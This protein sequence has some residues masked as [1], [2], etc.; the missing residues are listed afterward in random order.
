MFMF[1]GN[2]IE[3]IKINNTEIIW[4]RKLVISTSGMMNIIYHLLSQICFIKD[5]S[6]N[7]INE[8][9]IGGE[10]QN[11][12]L[13][14]GKHLELKNTKDNPATLKKSCVVTI[15]QCLLIKTNECFG[16]LGLPPE[17][18]SLVMLTGL[19]E[20]INRMWYHGR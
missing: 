5:Q 20:E 15:R 14:A 2:K 16:Q 6:F 7:G 11:A 8:T 12:T 17:L 18:L 19:A 4:P 1:L 10:G 3:K 13:I 9:D